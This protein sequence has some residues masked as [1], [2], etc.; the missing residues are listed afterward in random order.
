MDYRKL[1][2][3]GSVYS[4]PNSD[5]DNTVLSDEE[6]KYIMQRLLDLETKYFQD[7]PLSR[8]LKK[9]KKFI[10]NIPMPVYR[11][12]VRVDNEWYDN[13]ISPLFLLYPMLVSDMG[14][15]SQKI[16]L[17]KFGNFIDQD[18]YGGKNDE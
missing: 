16:F 9:Y 11:F 7:I 13:T 14:I 15:E 4:E 6:V 12:I 8:N 5:D 1:L 3:L 2:R 18:I 17:E 10:Y